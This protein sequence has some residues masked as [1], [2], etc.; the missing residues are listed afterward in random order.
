MPDTQ[1]PTLSVDRIDSG[2]GVTLRASGTWLVQKMAQKK[3]MQALQ[4]SVKSVQA[5]P[6]GSAGHEIQWDLSQI[7]RLDHIGAQFFWNLWGQTRPPGLM[8]A[9]G[10]ESLFARLAQA[11]AP[12]LPPPPLHPTRLAA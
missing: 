10:Q 11:G 1:N 8:L 2:S 7:D 6:A 3:V 4:G 9:P 5:M 12:A